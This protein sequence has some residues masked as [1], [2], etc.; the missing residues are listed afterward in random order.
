MRDDQPVQVQAE[1]A[2]EEIHLP[3]SSAI[4]LLTAIAVTLVVV[5]L[6]TSIIISL[7]GAVFLVLCLVRWVADTRH[8]IGEL[9]EAPSGD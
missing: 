6:G 8:D 1:P 4:P 7:I 9:P 2:G 3:G 5:G